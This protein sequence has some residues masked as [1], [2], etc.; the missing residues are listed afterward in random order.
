MAHAVDDVKIELTTGI[1]Y[2]NIVIT[3][4][5]PKDIPWQTPRRLR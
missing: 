2:T 4:D 1:M 5:I 3:R